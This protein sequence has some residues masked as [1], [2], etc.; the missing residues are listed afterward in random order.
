MEHHFVAA[1]VDS[2]A[3]V[4]ID[5]LDSLAVDEG[6]FL[7]RE[8]S[9]HVV[10]AA[11]LDHRVAL[12][13]R[14]IAEQADRIFLGAADRRARAFDSILASAQS[15]LLDGDPRG[16]GQLLHQADE[17]SDRKAGDRFAEE[18]R[19]QT[20]A[21]DCADQVEGD[22]ADGSANQSADRALGNVVHR[23]RRQSDAGADQRSVD[24]P[25]DAVSR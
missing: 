10:G 8:I 24:C 6:A 25:S 4:Q 11:S 2:I 18:S 17:Q 13:H 3:V 15:S 20:A 22:S 21:D 9:D 16:L 12:L 1:N 14:R 23:E 7:H 5:G 19:R